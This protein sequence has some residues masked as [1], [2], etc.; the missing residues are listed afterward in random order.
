MMCIVT[1]A[2]AMDEM[3]NNAGSAV[4]SLEK[5]VGCW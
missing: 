2:K 4:R 3:Q 5:K 1:A